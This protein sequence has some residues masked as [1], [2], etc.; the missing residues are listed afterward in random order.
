MFKIIIQ[1]LILIYIVFVVYSIINL[2][3][4]NINGVIIETNDIQQ[5]KNNVEYLNPVYTKDT[6]MYLINYIV[7]YQV[8]VSKRK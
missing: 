2:Q 6:I 4:F 8:V 7:Y 3:K 5:I 1:L